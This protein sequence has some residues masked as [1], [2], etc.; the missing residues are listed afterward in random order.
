MAQH[1]SSRSSF[2]IPSRE[3][4]RLFFAALADDGMLVRLSPGRWTVTTREG[5]FVQRRKG[6][7]PTVGVET[8]E[9]WGCWPPT[10]WRALD[11][12]AV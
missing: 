11:S 7:I 8:L 1:L 4:F 3:L 12:I 2:V 5:D 9:A 10:H 6:E